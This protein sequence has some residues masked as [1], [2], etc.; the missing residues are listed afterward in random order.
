MVLTKP[1]KDECGSKFWVVM[2]ILNFWLEFLGFKGVNPRNDGQNPKKL[3]FMK[4]MS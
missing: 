2:N 4:F 1:Y 3:K